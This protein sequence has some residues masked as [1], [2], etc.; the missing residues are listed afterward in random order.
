MITA[1]PQQPPKHTINL[2]KRREEKTGKRQHI[3]RVGNL[4]VIEERMP[5]IGE[6]YTSDGVRHG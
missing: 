2:A 6:W 1:T 3:I 4:F 5:L